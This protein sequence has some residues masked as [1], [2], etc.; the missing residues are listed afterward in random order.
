MA[1]LIQAVVN[2]VPANA[3]VHVEINQNPRSQEPHFEIQH[4]AVSQQQQ[5]QQPPQQQ[6]QQQQQTPTAGSGNNN[7]SQEQG[8][9][10]LILFQI[11][12]VLIA[13]SIIFC[14][15][16]CRSGFPHRF[17]WDY[18]T[19]NNRYAPNNINPNQVNCP[20]TGQC[21]S[22]TNRSHS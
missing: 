4:V 15:P 7:A 5:A 11:H 2:S 18:A 19:C 14:I 17:R 13:N 1:R 12:L 6:P 22:Y 8:T 16:I 21:F 3:D 10:L 9:I 20:P